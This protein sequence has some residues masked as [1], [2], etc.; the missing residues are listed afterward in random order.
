MTIRNK[1]TFVFVSI[2]LVCIVSLTVGVFHY[3]KKYLEENTLSQLEAIANIQKRR[4]QNGIKYNFERLN[5]VTNRGQLK[6]SLKEYQQR[7]SAKYKTEIQKTL[8]DAN[9][10]IPDFE[11]I[12]ILNPQGTVIIATDSNLEGSDLSQKKYV[13][14]SQV[15]ANLF[16]RDNQYG[17]LIL[18]GPLK[19][20]GELIGSVIIHANARSFFTFSQDYTGMGD[21]GDTM[22]AKQQHK[23]SVVIFA[24]RHYISDNYHPLSLKKENFSPSMEAALFGIEKTF[25]DTVDIRGYPVLSVSRFIPETGWAIIVNKHQQEAFASIHLLAKIILAIGLFMALIFSLT[26]HYFSKRI[27]RNVVQLHQGI[28]VISKGDLNFRLD[29]HSNDEIGEL[30]MA[31]NHMMEKLRSVTTSR[32]ELNGLTQE[33]KHLNQVKDKFISMAAH[34]LRTPI[35]VIKLNTDLYLQGM[36]GPMNDQQKKSL[37]KI[38]KVTNQMLELVNN[39][40][41]INIIE[42]GKLELEIKKIELTDY[43]NDFHSSYKAFARSKQID[44]SMDLTDD[45]PDIYIDPNRFNQVISN[46]V[47]NAIKF[48]HPKTKICLKVDYSDKFLNISITDE[49]IGISKEDQVKLF[50]PFVK[51]SNRATAGEKSTGL[52]L[53]ITKK[54]VEAHGGKIKIKSDVGKG[55]AVTIQLPIIPAFAAMNNTTSSKSEAA[56]DFQKKK[57]LTMRMF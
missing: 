30:S 40:L 3:A 43:L 10:S 28:K 27:T 23:D 17:K 31:F 12:L 5:A 49:G 29:V 45:L 34:D 2:T 48:S 32:D 50:K 19:L 36:Y 37:Q 35:S 14:H 16:L 21:T 26:I 41:D 13:I 24:S 1:L 44:W 54:I 4:V 38:V 52:G 47:T 33:L 55:T 11:N 20:N 39:M 56:P 22:I 25:R 53:V 42:S 7:K 46:L 15:K 18:A 51:L 9:K 8:Q 57:T 6:Q